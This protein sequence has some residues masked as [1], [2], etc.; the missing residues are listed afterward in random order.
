MKT[1]TKYLLLTLGI[2]GIILLIFNSIE[3]WYW[4]DTKLEL[5]I[6]QILFIIGLISFGFYFISEKWKNFLTKI[7][8]GIFG[9]SLALNIHLSTK[10]YKNL[11]HRNQISEYSELKT[12]EEM[13]N[14][15]AVDLKEGEVKYFHFNSFSTIEIKD[16]LKSKYDIEYFFMG[17][18]A[19]SEM[20][21][22]NKLVD[23][24][25]NKKHNT[26]INAIYKEIEIE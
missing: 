14:R 3:L 2:T 24:H 22:Y 9:I 13:E 10:S 8:I 26:S 20:I 17:C 16:I 18:L 1:R 7:M 23:K 6:S 25:L 19:N 4:Y 21:Y 5:E 11:Q 12:G 15:F